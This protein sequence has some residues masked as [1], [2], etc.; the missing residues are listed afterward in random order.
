MGNGGKFWA[1]A[2][3]IF[4]TRLAFSGTPD[5]SRRQQRLGSATDI[6]LAS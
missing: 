2:S 5:R 1:I 6:T 4:R 3:V